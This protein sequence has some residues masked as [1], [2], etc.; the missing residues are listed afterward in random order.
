MRGPIHTVEDHEEWTRIVEGSDSGVYMMQGFVVFDET[1][2]RAV[3]DKRTVEKATRR[4]AQRKGWDEAFAVV[5][6]PMTTVRPVDGETFDRRTP[7]TVTELGDAGGWWLLVPVDY[8]DG[9]DD[10]RL[11]FHIR[12]GSSDLIFRAVEAV[13]LRG[14]PFPKLAEFDYTVE[15]AVKDK[16]LYTYNDHPDAPRLARGLLDN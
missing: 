6:G 12:Q 7:S 10:P 5:I 9:V 14:G 1:M 2:N 15:Y 16:C 13:A 8:L 4:L 3:T 11:E